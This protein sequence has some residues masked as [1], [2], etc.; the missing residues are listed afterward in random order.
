VSRINDN[1]NN[2]NNDDDN[3]NDRPEQKEDRWAW[4]LLRRGSILASPQ[5][6]DL[7]RLFFLLLLGMLLLQAS[8]RRVQ[9]CSL[10]VALPWPAAAARAA[11][12][13]QQPSRLALTAVTHAA[14]RRPVVAV[15]TLVAH[16]LLQ[17]HRAATHR[18]TPQQQRRRWLAAADEPVAADG[19]D[20]EEAVPAERE[21]A[22]LTTAMVTS[23]GFYKNFVSPLLPPACR[24]LPTCSR[25]GVQ[26]IE[27]FGPCKGGVLTAWR[28][29][30]TV[31]SL[32][33]FF[34]AYP[35]IVIPIGTH[36][37]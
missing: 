25:Y 1:D 18:R 22:P 32:Y 24:F 29:C 17:E 36:P 23:I 27:E 6:K 28:T 12:A 14:T 13:R 10:C 26:A 21:K 7:M 9:A 20:T 8:E 37:L 15:A 35:V 11:V 4:L 3:D 2:D 5:R 31:H 16:R 19:A 34:C 33:R 30:R